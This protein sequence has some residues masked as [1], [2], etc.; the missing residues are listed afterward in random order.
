MDS[1]FHDG[2][3]GVVM[4]YLGCFGAGFERPLARRRSSS[5]IA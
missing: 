1:E 3:L 5:V 2:L 4:N